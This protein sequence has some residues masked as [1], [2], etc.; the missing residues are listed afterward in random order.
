MGFTGRPGTVIAVPDQLTVETCLA[1]EQAA[2]WR[3]EQGDADVVFDLT[4]TESID[5]SGLALLIT[6]SRD[7]KQYSRR[8]RIVGL[9]DHLRALFR[10]A[11]IE[12]LFEFDASVEAAIAAAQ[13]SGVPYAGSARRSS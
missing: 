7:A 5:G 10:L 4:E 1:V 11:R 13:A 6:V 2:R 9:P 12:G 3:L 8:V